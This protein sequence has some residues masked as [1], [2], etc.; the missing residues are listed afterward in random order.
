VDRT[1]LRAARTPISFRATATAVEVAASG[2][3]EAPSLV[4]LVAGIDD[5]DASPSTVATAAV[6]VPDPTA[7]AGNSARRSISQM[8]L[9][10]TRKIVLP[11][12]P[13]R[14]SVDDGQKLP[15]PEKPSGTDRTPAPSP[16]RMNP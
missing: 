10:L 9:I 13:S 6:P 3:R 4:P 14:K 15:G 12:Y 1:I 2:P 8:G 7:S 5:P 16:E 11:A